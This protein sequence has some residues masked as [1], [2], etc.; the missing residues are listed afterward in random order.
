MSP[1]KDVDI[2]LENIRGHVS[3]WI[4]QTGVNKKI[5][6]VFRDFLLTYEDNEKGKEYVQKI[7]S[8]KSGVRHELA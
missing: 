1:L 2:D 3:E 5:R 8:M 4:V 7:T 6:R